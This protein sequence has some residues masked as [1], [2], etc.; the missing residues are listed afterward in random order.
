[1]AKHRLR[2]SKVKTENIQS[3]V[4][5]LEVDQKLVTI[6]SFEVSNGVKSWKKINTLSIQEKTKSEFQ[7]F[8]NIGYHYGYNN[9]TVAILFLEFCHNLIFISFVTI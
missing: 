1:M 2:D 4:F 5:K 3:Q 8:Q 9:N 6:L 7:N